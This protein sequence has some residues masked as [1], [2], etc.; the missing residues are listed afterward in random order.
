MVLS[1]KDIFAF[2]MKKRDYSSFRSGCFGKQEGPEK[3]GLMASLSEEAFAAPILTKN[4]LKA[5]NLVVEPFNIDNLKGDGIDF[6]IG[7]KIY[8]SDVLLSEQI[9][10]VDLEEMVSCGGAREINL[11]EGEKFDFEAGII[12]YVL[13]KEKVKIPNNLK[14]I[15]DSKSTIGRLG[16]LCHDVTKQELFRTSPVN[17]ISVVRPYVFTIRATAG[18]S[19]L[20]QGVFTYSKEFHMTREDILKNRDKVEVSV[21]R[22][23]ILLEDALIEDKLALHFSTHKAYVS[24]PEALRAGA[25]DIEAEG[26]N[27]PNWGDYFEEIKGNDKI[28]LEKD[29]F[30]LLGTREHIKFGTV[31]GRLSRDYGG[32]LTGLWSQF[33]GIIHAG[34]YGEI[35]LECKTTEKRVIKNGDLA[36]TIEIDALSSD[37]GFEAK[38]S[39]QGQKAPRLSKVFAPKK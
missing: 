22:K 30:Y 23:K 38:G 3:K 20:F 26:D 13:S 5:N 25:I 14:L 4:S 21:N 9:S 16:C 27:K 39:Y 24:R 34:F 32:H 35:T 1:D 36:G 18:K 11:K 8:S 37:K 2:L 7:T 15:V 29:R 17:L 19:K 31:C 12:Y 33:A 28:I 10:L 6:T